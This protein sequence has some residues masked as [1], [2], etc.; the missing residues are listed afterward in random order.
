LKFSGFGSVLPPYRVQKIAQD[1]EL[2]LLL[3]EPVEIL[4]WGYGVTNLGTF[5]RSTKASLV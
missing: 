2:I 1:G 4:E 5:C 3:I